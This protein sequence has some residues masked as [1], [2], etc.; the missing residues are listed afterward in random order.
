M[1][2]MP[3]PLKELPIIV[4][5][6][7]APNWHNGAENA[8]LLGLTP[9]VRAAS[10]AA[11][12]LPSD[13]EG[14]LQ[15]LHR[16]LHETALAQKRVKWFAVRIFNRLSGARSNQIQLTG[17]QLRQVL[18][19][20]EIEKLSFVKERGQYLLRSDVARK[21]HDDLGGYLGVADAVLARGLDDL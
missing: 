5:L 19:P 7:A 3:G 20:S 16:K 17:A 11:E 1:S 12:L 8:V 2:R 6:K 4:P 15:I 10:V 9:L 18:S 21:L 14:C 13:P